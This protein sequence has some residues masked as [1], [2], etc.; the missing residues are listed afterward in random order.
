MSV[1]KRKKKLAATAAVVPTVTLFARVSPEIHA[2][3]I[4]LASKKAEREGRQVPLK[5]I[6]TDLIRDA[7]L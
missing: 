2:R 5:E 6:V 4:A 3:L 1:K 7:S